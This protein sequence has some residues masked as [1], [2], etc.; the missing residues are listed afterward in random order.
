MKLRLCVTL[1]QQ[2]SLQ[3]VQAYCRHFL[4]SSRG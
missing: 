1:I 4:A 2:G 3:T